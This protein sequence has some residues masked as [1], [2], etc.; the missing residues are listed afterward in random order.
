MPIL[1]M[2]QVSDKRISN[3]NPKT[4]GTSLLRSHTMDGYF[5]VY[6]TVISYTLYEYARIISPK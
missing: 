3:G 5:I 1:I 2:E 6:P 4:T